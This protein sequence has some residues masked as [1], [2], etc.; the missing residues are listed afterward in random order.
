MTLG[1]LALW[2]D[3]CPGSL[4]L[5]EA[6][7]GFVARVRVPGGRV[8][9]AGV[10][11]L[12]RAAYLGSGLVE[13]TSRA[14][15][16]L[17]GLPADAADELSAILTGAGLLPSAA[18]DRS[19]NVIASPVAGRHPDSRASTD[20]VVAELD[21]RLCADM[22]L[23]D[24]PG[25]FL[26]AIDDGS[27]M[28]IDRRADVQLMA[29]DRRRFELL[30]MGVVERADAAAA[31]LDLARDY[32]TGRRR[33]GSVSR[34]GRTLDP[35]RVVQQDGRVAVTGLAPLGQLDA[36]DLASLAELFAEVRFG[37]GRT[38]TV[39][40]LDEADGAEAELSLSELGLVLEPREGWVGL[41]ACAGRGRCAKARLDVRAAA[42]D[43]A[44]R[45]PA[46]APAEH[47][48]A[49]ER[50]CGER[51]EQP[52]AVAALAEGVSVRAAGSES[53]VADLDQ[54]RAQLA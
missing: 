46:G 54:A 18:H 49:C 29:L 35:G 42:A 9:A 43:R 10:R 27:G 24:L 30:G 26:F 2:A 11:A 28:A 22:A 51:P 6:A 44:R 32:L 12:A 3:R 4:R 50:R 1:P 37:A 25:R 48:A 38:V 19:R 15:V 45:R 23:A 33:P 21:H 40:D 52:V 5:H 47:W 20:E 31:A 36:G 34:S 14:N 17:R 13:V 8:N 53:I 39:L 41:T 16:Q 7:D